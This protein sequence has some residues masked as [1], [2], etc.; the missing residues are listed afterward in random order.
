MRMSEENW[1]VLVSLFP[2]GWQQMAFQSGAIRGFPPLRD[3]WFSHVQI[4]ES[5]RG[6]SDPAVVRRFRCAMPNSWR[7]GYSER[8][9]SKLAE[10]RAFARTQPLLQSWNSMRPTPPRDR[11]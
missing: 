11:S 6:Q 3:A 4:G 2:A 5:G 1:K 10:S 9:D 7:L 8:F